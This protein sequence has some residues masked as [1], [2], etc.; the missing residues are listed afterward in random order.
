MSVRSVNAISH[1][2]DWTIGHVHSGAL[3]WVSMISVGAIYYIWPRLTE[4]PLYSM[5]LVNWHYWVSTVGTLLYVTSLWIAGIM[6][7]LMWRQIKPDGSLAYS[8]V[9][10]MNALQPYYVVRLVGGALFLSGMVLMA[11][12]L[13]RTSAQPADS[14]TRD[15]QPVAA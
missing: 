15:A 2:T 6:Q 3:G 10:T 9:E 5:K 8:F 1:Y 13:Y 7:S 4:R 14:V 12:N 11:Y